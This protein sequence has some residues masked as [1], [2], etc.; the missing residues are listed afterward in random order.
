MEGGGVKER[1]VNVGRLSPQFVSMCPS[2]AGQGC[3][4]LL[5]LDGL[6]S[7]WRV[8]GPFI[9]VEGALLWALR[10][11]GLDER[12]EDGPAIAALS[13]TCVGFD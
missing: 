13:G 4:W 8:E 12:R 5:Y 7:W 9:P 10:K 6:L 3:V 1:E 2:T 11:Q